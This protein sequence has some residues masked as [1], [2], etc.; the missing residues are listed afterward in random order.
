[1]SYSRGDLLRGLP[2]FSVADT[3]STVSSGGEGGGGEDNL[4]GLAALTVAPVAQGKTKTYRL[5][6]GYESDKWCLGMIGSGGHTFCIN[7][8][9]HVKH[10]GGEKF[11]WEEGHLY[12][13]KE[14]E[15]AFVAPSIS[16]KLLH[17]TLSQQWLQASKSWHEWSRL[18]GMAKSAGENVTEED[19]MEQEARESKADA[20]KT[21]YKKR[22]REEETIE[23]LDEEIIYSPL[24][25]GELEV[26]PD[27]LAA[28][29]RRVETYIRDKS[30]AQLKRFTALES[31][32]DI[33]LTRLDSLSYSIGTR[34]KRIKA[35]YDGP[36]IWTTISLLIDEVE[37]GFG[38]KIRDAIN[39]TSALVPPL[40]DKILNTKWEDFKTKMN[41]F[42]SQILSKQEFGLFL[43][44]L[45]RK[46][47]FHDSSINRLNNE[48]TLLKTT[49]SSAPSPGF[50]SWSGGTGAYS[51]GL[52][53]SKVEDLEKEINFLKDNFA[54]LEKAT[55]K[56]ENIGEG[57]V[58]YASLGFYD[59]NDAL[60]FVSGNPDC[61]RFG[62]FPNIYTLCY[63]IFTQMTGQEGYL[64][65]ME[66]IKKLSLHS[67]GEATA[68]VAFGSAIPELFSKHGYYPAAKKTS[69]FSR[70][71]N[72]EAWDT[73]KRKI[74]E[75][76]SVQE[77]AMR[78]SIANLI[79]V[80]SQIRR[81]CELAVADSVS[82]LQRFIRWMDETYLDLTAN[83]FSKTSAWSLVTQLGSRY[84]QELFKVR[85][86]ISD[87]FNIE[88][89]TK[90]AANVWYGV[91]RT[92]DVMNEFV[93]MD[94]KNH[95]AM[96]SEYVK[97]LATNSGMELI[98]AIDGKLKTM[99]E[100]VRDLKQAAQSAT[101]AATSAANKADD[102]SKKLAQL[103]RD[104]DKRLKAGNL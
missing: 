63:K 91:A 7:D 34:P 26:S 38:T 50:G 21:P 10:R 93:T 81:I 92:H 89:T 60:A 86:G 94:F 16:I 58:V 75:G 73:T 12:V 72:H 57:K 74:E 29:L 82:N 97:F 98:E 90:L 51:F 68:L 39:Q 96:S 53:N 49:S 5:V 30:E 54:S 31:T 65:N 83:G 2:P 64:K 36:T 71:E 9:C 44:D 48:V 85:A 46:L 13:L 27:I 20:F 17:P 84:F 52:E 3:P 70:I 23:P 14:P 67:P 69:H 80:T 78:Q 6:L 8:D 102:V 18:F 32:Q 43:E 95:P 19:L 79:P 56:V 87:T 35:E 1:M 25:K 42:Q 77:Q 101:K 45:K 4:S 59:M 76:L 33:A 11:P 28:S 61:L 55:S 103:Q 88:N 100:E 24:L 15:V 41:E 66:T 37:H 22:G 62:L 104:H 47:G 99:K 40:V